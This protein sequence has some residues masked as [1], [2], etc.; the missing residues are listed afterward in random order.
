MT[1]P[2]PSPPVR[3]LALVRI[4]MLGGTLLIGL[5]LWQ[6]RKVA[7]APPPNDSAAAALQVAFI[8][9]AVLAVVFTIVVQR[10]IV[11]GDGVNRGGLPIVAWA[12]GEAPALLGIVRYYLSGDARSYLV[13]L[14]IFLAT[15]VLI[16]VRPQR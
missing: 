2:P 13:G 3:T 10:L 11:R 15:L 5:V 12:M 1:S 4:A 6:L 8:V 7:G 9:V 14:L 16:P